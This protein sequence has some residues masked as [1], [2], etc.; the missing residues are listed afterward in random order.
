MH[1]AFTKISIFVTIDLELIIM[2]ITISPIYFAFVFFPVNID[3][4]C[5]VLANAIPPIYAYSHSV[6]KSVVGGYVYRGCR[7]PN[8][9]GKYIFADTM[10]G[11][12]I[13]IKATSD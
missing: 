4:I 10:T 2:I 3:S 6:G 8:L 13:L 7:N 1:Y 9:Y 11:Y 5:S 12:D